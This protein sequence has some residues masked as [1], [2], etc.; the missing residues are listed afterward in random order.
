MHAQKV[1]WTW[2]GVARAVVVCITVSSVACAGDG[3]E[4]TPTSPYPV[5]VV[6]DGHPVNTSG[7]D[8]VCLYCD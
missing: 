1:E 7:T 5:E 4:P 8:F 3:G 6:Q 2:G